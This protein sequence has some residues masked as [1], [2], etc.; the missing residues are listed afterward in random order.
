MALQGLYRRK[1]KT[2]FEKG[3]QN[4]Q[5]FE[6]SSPAVGQFI[7]VFADQTDAEERASIQV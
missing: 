1:R 6:T 2:D 4:G 5:E 7:E 3:K